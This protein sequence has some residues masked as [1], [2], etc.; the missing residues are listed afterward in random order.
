MEI[1][2]IANSGD[3]ACWRE[4]APVLDLLLGKLKPAER[5]ALLLRFFEERS[6]KEIGQ[7][8]GCGETGASQR[9]SRALEK[10]RVLLARKGITCSTT[11]LS[12]NLV[13]H[14]IQP[15]SAAVLSALA[16]ASVAE[17]ATSGVSAVGILNLVTMTKLKSVILGSV[18]LIGV[19]TP[20][21][22]QHREIVNLRDQHHTLRSDLEQVSRERDDALSR[23]AALSEE[24]ERSKL[25][26][27]E[28]LRLRAERSSLLSQRESNASPKPDNPP[29]TASNHVTQEEID[30]FLQRPPSEQGIALGSVR[31]N[32][33]NHT[34]DG[35]LARNMEIAKAVRLKLDNLE[36]NPSAFA[37]FQGNFIASVLGVENGTTLERMQ[38][39]IEAIYKEAISKGLDAPS[40]PQTNAEEWMTKRDAL[41]REGTK[42]FK[43]LLTQEQAERFDLAFLGIMGIDVGINDGAWHRFSDEDG[44]IIFPSETPTK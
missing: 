44:T 28:L 40:R 18:L 12:S 7:M 8:V 9:I 15:L 32:L 23:A 36:A 20:I 26:S 29:L 34:A 3:E 14:A 35:E 11:A 30:A 37:A 27:A 25:N 39:V 6:L 33:L 24:N 4:I 2:E 42:Q 19:G 41:D 17:A 43:A 10:L 5:D 21:L 1:E 13:S 22:F 31:R 16:V 38:E